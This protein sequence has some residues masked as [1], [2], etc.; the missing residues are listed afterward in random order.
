[1]TGQETTPTIAVINYDMGNWRSAQKALEY[2]GARAPRTNDRQEIIAA[3]GLVLPGVGAFPKA[4]KRLAERDLITTINRF[5]ALGKPILGICLGH[6][7]LFEASEEHEYTKGLGFI[8]GVVR[9]TP[10][11]AVNMGWRKA[12]LTR[13]TALTS[14]LPEKYFY[15]MHALAAEP[16]DPADVFAFSPYDV[17][18]RSLKK[19][20]MVVSAIQR[21]NLYGVQFH[22]EKSSRQGLKLIS[23]FVQ[24]CRQ[25]QA[26]L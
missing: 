19:S 7:L 15:H 13:E 20:T 12:T 8:P 14:G 4:M 6:Q 1:M 11:S 24:I 22:P 17:S 18:A 5:K 3:D 21:D 2:V 23:N 26:R 25:G 10:Y 16:E 9:E